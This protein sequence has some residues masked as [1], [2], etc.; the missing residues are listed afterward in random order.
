MN[1]PK[2]IRPDAPPA[3]IFELRRRK[4][5]TWFTMKVNAPL[6]WKPIL[7]W[8]AGLVAFVAAITRIVETIH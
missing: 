2:Q 4:E 5:D 7:R 6:R 1:S 3:L 8:I